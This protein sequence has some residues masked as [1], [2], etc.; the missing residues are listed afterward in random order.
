[1]NVIDATSTNDRDIVKASQRELIQIA[2]N[3]RVEKI[4]IKKLY[5]SRKKNAFE[6]VSF[7]TLTK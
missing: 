1:M 7:K 4:N 5:E 6:I 2:K 3:V